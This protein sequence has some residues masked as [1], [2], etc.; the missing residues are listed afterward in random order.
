MSGR[1]RRIRKVTRASCDAVLT[2]GNVIASTLELLGA[3]EE[4]ASLAEAFDE[5]YENGKRRKR[6]ISSAK[7]RP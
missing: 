5:A 1:S 7:R 6:A 3:L 2:T 4:G